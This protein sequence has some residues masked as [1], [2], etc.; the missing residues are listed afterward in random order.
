MTAAQHR[1]IILGGPWAEVLAGLLFVALALVCPPGSVAFWIAGL[2]G[3]EGLYFG[4]AS[5][6]P[7]DRDGRL[8]DGGAL[9]RLRGIEDHHVVSQPLA[10]RFG[11]EP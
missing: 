11:D 8:N 4:F 2:S 3:L 5:L 9:A 10:A 7:V 6:R 1:S